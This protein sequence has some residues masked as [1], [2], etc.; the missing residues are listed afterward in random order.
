MGSRDENASIGVVS[1]NGDDFGIVGALCGDPRFGDIRIGAA[2]LAENIYALAI[3]A[4]DVISGTWV[5]DVIF[6]S[7]VQ[8]ADLDEVF[9]VRF[10]R[11]DMFWVWIILTSLYR[12]CTCMASPQ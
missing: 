4:G 2:P 7:N 10:M 12:R 6:N 11:R 5:G 8:F 1:D 3:P 9:A